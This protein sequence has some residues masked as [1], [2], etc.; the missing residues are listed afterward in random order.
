MNI[1]LEAHPFVGLRRPRTLAVGVALTL[2]LFHRLGLD[3]VDDFLEWLLVVLPAVELS[4]LAGLGALVNDAG[5]DK[6][7]VESGWATS[8]AV[9]RWFGFT[10]VANWVLAI[11]VTATLKAYVRLGGPPMIML[12]V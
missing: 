11:G 9:L 12:P 2:F 1:K 5:R 6:G 10:V 4:G 8:V 3:P 7:G